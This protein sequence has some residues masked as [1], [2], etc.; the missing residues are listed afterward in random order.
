MRGHRRGQQGAILVLTAFLLPFIIAFTGM[1]VDFGSAYVRRSQMQNAADAA[2]LAGAYHLDDNQADDVVLKYLKTNLDPHFTSYSYQTGD[3]FPDQ[4]ETLNYHTDKQ[5]DEL[6]VTLRSSVEASFLKLF[7]IN[8]IPV[9]VTA[10]AKVSSEEN[11]SVPSDDMFNYAI[12]TGQG[13][14]L[15]DDYSDPNTSGLYVNTTNVTIEGNIR[16][17]GRIAMDQ[18]RSNT[19][20]GKIYTSEDVTYGTPKFKNFDYGGF[21]GTVDIDPNVWGRYGWYNGREE[22]YTFVDKDGQPISKMELK[23]P[24]DPAY[25][26][27]YYYKTD[28]DKVKY[29]DDIDISI[30]KNKGIQS[31]IE[32]YRKMKPEDREKNHV[33]FDDDETKKDSWYSFHSWQENPQKTYPNLTMNGNNYYRVIIVPGNLTVS[34]ENSLQPTKDEFFIFISLYGNI[35]VPSN[36]PELNGIIYAPNK[37][38]TVTMQTYNTN[39]NGSIVADR[40]VITGGNK[41]IRWANYLSGGS[42]SSGDGKKTVH[43][44]K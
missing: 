25:K 13:A 21:K 31:L 44:V 33:Y 3:D 6:D 10:T 39:F 19:L 1:A 43:L 5:K 15:R 14:P 20:L 4:F 30:E 23:Y 40:V 26:D 34:F 27:I 42:N 29:G 28:A 41:T 17:N 12:T 18:S 32:K 7:D 24:D 36:L 11:P 8:T 9:S 2:A 22:F 38:K 16:T 37:N 35:T